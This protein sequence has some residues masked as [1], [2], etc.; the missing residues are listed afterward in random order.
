MNMD[1]EKY[2]A[3]VPGFPKKGIVFLDVTPIFRDGEAYNYA[4]T[5]LADYAKSK[6]ANVV[7]GPEARGF[8]TGCPVATK[9]NIGFAPIRKPGKLPREVVTED[10]DLEY[11]K[12]TLCLHKDAIKPGDKVVIIDDLLATGGTVRAGINLVERLGGE[13]VGIA[14]LIE[15]TDLNGKDLLEGYDVYSLMKFK[16]N[17]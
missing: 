3:K 17:E 2:V 5:K 13:V 11:G 4:I 1:L 9:L 15:L 14:F 7:V 8:M 6:G 12:N 16:E 10:Y